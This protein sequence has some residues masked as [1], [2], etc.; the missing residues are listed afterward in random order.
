MESY[1]K[2]AIEF[3]RR[4]GKDV[5]YVSSDK[6][7]ELEKVGTLTPEIQEAYSLGTAGPSSHFVSG[8][9]FT[10][11]LKVEESKMEVLSKVIPL[12]LESSRARF[13]SARRR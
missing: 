9:K 8:L 13:G 6:Y 12:I 11:A 10:K 1:R 3:Q 7:K 2:S 4:F 5:Y